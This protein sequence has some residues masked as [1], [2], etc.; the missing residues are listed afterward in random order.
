MLERFKIHTLTGVYCLL[1]PLKNKSFHASF[2]HKNC[3]GHLSA[4]FLLWQIL[5]LNLRFAVC[6]KRDNSNLPPFVTAF[7]N[8]SPT[9]NTNPLLPNQNSLDK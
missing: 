1:L 8:C 9:L 5:N 3:S 4:Y 7:E 6:R 2:M